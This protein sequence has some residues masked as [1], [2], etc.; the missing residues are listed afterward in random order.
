MR[1][2]RC[3]FRFSISPACLICLWIIVRQLFFAGCVIFSI[4]QLFVVY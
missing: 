3:T 4:E 2:S 1:A